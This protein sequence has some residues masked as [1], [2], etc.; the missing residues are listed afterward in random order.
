MTPERL[1][2]LKKF[3]LEGLL[4]SDEERIVDSE[5]KVGRISQYWQDLAHFSLGVYVTLKP[6]SV[7][8]EMPETS[9]SYKFIFVEPGI[10]MGDQFTL[11]A[12]TEGFHA[13]IW[14]RYKENNK[15]DTNKHFFEVS[16]GS[17]Q[18]NIL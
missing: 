16:K 18:V 1:A 10:M 13:N 17:E 3:N 7:R 11:M 2:T 5:K 12:G 14:A 15:N 6:A 4:L 9:G 8:I